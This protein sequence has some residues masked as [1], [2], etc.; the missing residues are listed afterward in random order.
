MGTKPKS[1]RQVNSAEIKKKENAVSKNMRAAQSAKPKGASK[2]AVNVMKVRKPY[3][4][5]SK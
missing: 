3:A 2:A 4:K 5:T 1:G